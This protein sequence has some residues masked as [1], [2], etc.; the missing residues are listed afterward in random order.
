MAVLYGAVGNI[1][2][3]GVIYGLVEA[4]FGVCKDVA[5]EHAYHP[6]PALVKHG[7]DLNRAPMFY[8]FE[9]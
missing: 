7:P 3:V 8:V 4:V 1:Q 5:D 6:P 9:G 2:A